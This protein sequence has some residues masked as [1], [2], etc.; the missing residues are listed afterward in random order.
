[1][2]LSRSDTNY[3]EKALVEITLQQPLTVGL[4]TAAGFDMKPV[5]FDYT[6]DL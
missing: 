3:S 1:M 6:Q 4:W 2:K 5:K